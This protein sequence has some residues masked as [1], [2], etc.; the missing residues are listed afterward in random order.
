MTHTPNTDKNPNVPTIDLDE[1]SAHLQPSTYSLE[2]E[3]SATVSLALAYLFERPDAERDELHALMSLTLARLRLEKL[4]LASPHSSPTQSI[5]LEIIQDFIAGTP[6]DITVLGTQVPVEVDIPD[7]GLRVST[8]VDRVDLAEDGRSASVV[9]YRF[10][11][12]SA[13]GSS[14]MSDPQL[15][16]VVAASESILGK[17]AVEFQRHLLF[18]RRSQVVEFDAG[19]SAHALAHLAEYVKSVGDSPEAFAESAV[20]VTAIDPTEVG[21]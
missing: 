4:G 19:D 2:G 8:I 7:L 20:R 13:S 11:N 21:A 12:C 3:V 17:P 5:S 1:A 16:T 18:Q 10:D 9:A 14:L 6:T 15:L